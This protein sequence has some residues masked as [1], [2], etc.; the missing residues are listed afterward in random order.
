MGIFSFLFG[1]KTEINKEIEDPEFG[2]LIWNDDDESWKGKYAGIDILLSFETG[3][4]SPSNELKKYAL[5]VLN[6]PN[7]LEKALK[8]EKEK[9][10]AAYP[11]YAMEVNGLRYA[12]INFYRYKSRVN[13]MIASLEPGDDY[14]AW[15]IEFEE[16]KCEGLGFDS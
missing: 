10:I 7:V 9:F 2:T 16:Y 14:R 6:N 12:I 3:L 4:P 1:D 8:V 13:R 5:S 11:E 15:R